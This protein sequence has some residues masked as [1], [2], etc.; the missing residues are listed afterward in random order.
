[1]EE[2]QVEY[3]K[4]AIQGCK[5]PGRAPGATCCD[6]CGQTG[7]QKHS[8][9]R[10]CN[11]QFGPVL[12]PR[13]RDRDD[14]DDDDGDDEYYDDHRRKGKGKGKGKAKKSDAKAQRDRDRWRSWE[15]NR[16]G[17]RKSWNPPDSLGL[18]RWA[19][20]HQP[21][22]APSRGCAPGTGSWRPWKK[23]KW[24]RGKRCRVSS[25][26]KGSKL[27]WHAWRAKAI[28]LQSCTCPRHY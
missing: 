8:L 16:R 2:I 25:R 28:A 21:W 20:R 9:S 17:I 7:G 23:R 27:E 19:V 10:A 24:Y 18:W 4:C 15:W 5:R 3:H 11:N 14:D 22:S 6:P 12:P 26:P 13:E 1:M